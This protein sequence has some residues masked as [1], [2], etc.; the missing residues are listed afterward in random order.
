MTAACAYQTQDLASAHA[1]NDNAPISART[2]LKLRLAAQWRFDS[3]DQIPHRVYDGNLKQVKSFISDGK[4]YQTIYN[5]FDSSGKLV[6]IYNVTKNE[7]TEYVTGPTG[8]IARVTN[9]TPTYMH[10]DHLGSAQ[11]GTDHTGAVKWREQYTPFGE[12]I[13]NPAA[14]DN[15]DGFTGHIKDKATGLNYMQARYYDPVIGRFLSIDPVTFMDNGNPSYFNRYRYC[16][17]DPANC[18][19]PNG[20]TDI[21]IGGANDKRKDGRGPVQSY[22]S[23]LKSQKGRTVGYFTAS[24][25]K[26]ATAFARK[27]AGNGEPLNIIG[28]SYGT[29]AAANVAQELGESGTTVN[30]LIGVDSVNKPLKSGAADSEKILTTVSVNATGTGS[31]GDRVEAAGKLVGGGRAEAFEEGNATVFVNTDAHHEEFGKA[32]ENSGARNVIDESYK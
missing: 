19:D 23:G 1:A 4:G 21:Y 9:G 32:F 15:L 13:Q 6:H 25:K 27:H 17:N 24:Q 12:Q 3:S 18:I 10:P 11:A 22:Y 7:K 20:E 8:T 26:E 28:H 16:A 30:N 31:G 5:I 29:V 2:K 14:N